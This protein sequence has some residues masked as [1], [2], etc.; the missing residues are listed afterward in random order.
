MNIMNSI[1]IYAVTPK[2]AALARTLAR[3][4][5]GSIF[6]PERMIDAETDLEESGFQN[7][8]ECVAE[9]FCR[10]S[11]HIFITAAG[12]A[13]RA[14]AQHLVSKD[15]DPAVIVLDQNGDHVISLLSG[16]LGGANRL[17]QQIAQI[18]GGVAVI[19]TATDTEQL[20][21]IDMIAQEAG[22][23]IHN[24]SV[25]KHINGALLAGEQVILDDPADVLGLKRDAFEKY[26]LPAE[27][28][29]FSEEDAPSI[30][31]SWR[32]AELLEPEEK[33][34]LLHPKVLTVGVGA[35]RGAS[36]D[37]VLQLIRETFSSHDLAMESIACL[38]SV[39]AK[40]NEL[41]II[42]AANTLGVPFLTVSAELLDTID[43]PNPSDAP[44]HAVGTKSVA[45]AAAL[46]GALAQ[47]SAR[48][49]VEK[50]KGNGVTCAVALEI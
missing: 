38:V 17:S 30:V 12:I 8:R 41:G 16:H 15:V 25:V 23:S 34:L 50:Q 31:V 20:P 43:V 46:H 11:A 22:C 44:K 29:P 6:L 26:F 39:D 10:C 40:K 42:Q 3:E 47:Q 5:G 18:V 45:E 36:K 24:L 28:V 37:A 32:S 7:L 1:A 9:T 27:L 48:L 13:V 2:G 35:K 33:T 4:V 21:S 49:V 19:T 14:I